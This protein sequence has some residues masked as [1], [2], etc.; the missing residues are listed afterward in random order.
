[1]IQ[2]VPTIN[3][4]E[5]HIAGNWK[6]DI[7]WGISGREGRIYKGE[8]IRRRRFSLADAGYFFFNPPYRLFLPSHFQG[9]FWHHLPKSLFPSG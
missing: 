9:A 5:K 7:R 6:E 2:Q 8:R 3:F 4:W 1:M